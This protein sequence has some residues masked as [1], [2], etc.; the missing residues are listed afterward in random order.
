[1]IWFWGIFYVLNLRRDCFN[2]KFVDMKLSFEL[3]RKIFKI[4]IK[5]CILSLT[6]RL[7]IFRVSL[8]VHIE[9]Y[10]IWFGSNFVQILILIY[11]VPTLSDYSSD[12][13]YLTVQTVHLFDLQFQQFIIQ[14]FHCFLWMDLKSFLEF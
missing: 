11:N 6:L 5:G 2:F 12:V 8:R 7:N 10:F 13:I 9:K 14:D 1:M 3:F 4:C